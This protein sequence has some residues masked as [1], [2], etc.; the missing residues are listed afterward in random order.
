M[1]RM[2]SNESYCCWIV[3]IVA[4][5]KHDCQWTIKIRQGP[6]SHGLEGGNLVLVI[7]H[8]LNPQEN[9]LPGAFQAAVGWGR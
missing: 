6:F 9:K 1:N 4:R 2:D 3:F 7:V 5:F 8:G